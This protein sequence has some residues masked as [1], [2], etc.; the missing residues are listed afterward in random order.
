M[1]GAPLDDAPFSFFSA[2]PLLPPFCYEIESEK[3]CD[4]ET[5]RLSFL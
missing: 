2:P 1:G 4:Q 3:I 5:N